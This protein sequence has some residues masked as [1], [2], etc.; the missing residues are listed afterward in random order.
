MRLTCA[1]EK[2]TPESPEWLGCNTQGLRNIVC[3][4]DRSEF[5]FL[6]RQFLHLPLQHHEINKNPSLLVLAS[7]GF[8]L[9]YG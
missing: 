1:P 4:A 8:F 3:R 7:P 9:G 2:S 5:G 6:F